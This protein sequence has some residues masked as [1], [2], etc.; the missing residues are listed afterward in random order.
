MANKINKVS[1]ETREKIRK[2]SVLNLPN[3][4]IGNPE[5]V[6]QAFTGLVIDS[7]NSALGEIDR[8]VEEI[9][10]KFDYLD[11]RVNTI[12]TTP[13][14]SVSAEE[15]IDA[16]QGEVTL[17]AN[18][19][20]VKSQ[21]ADKASLNE[22]SRKRDKSVPIGLNDV[23]PELL[24]AIEGGEGTSFELLS[25]PRDGSVTREKFDKMKP[26]KNVFDKSKTFFGYNISATNGKTSELSTRNLSDFTLIDPGA[27]YIIAQVET[28][29]FFDA[30]KNYISGQKLDAF[31]ANHLI[32]TPSNA[33]YIRF[34]WNAVSFD[35][36]RQMLTKGSEIPD[37]YIAYK[38]S[39][40]DLE[41][42]EDNLNRSLYQQLSELK[43]LFDERAY[44]GNLFNINAI[45]PFKYLN[46]NNGDLIDSA[47]R[48][49]SDFIPI[50]PLTLY[51]ISNLRSYVFYDENKNYIDGMQLSDAKTDYTIEAPRLARY[52]RFDY[53]QNTG[54]KQMVVEGTTVP[55]EFIPFGFK[56]PNLIIDYNNLDEALSLSLSKETEGKLSSDY[57]WQDFTF[58][59]E[60]I[61]AFRPSDVGSADGTREVYILDKDTLALNKTLRHNFGHA[62]TIDYCAETDSLIFGNG[63]G[64]YNTDGEI[65][66]V[67]GVKHLRNSAENTLIDING[68]TEGTLITKIEVFREFGDKVNVCWGEDNN[69]LHNICYVLSN[70]NVN[71]RKLLLG[72]GSNQFDNGQFISGRNENEFNGTYKI[73]SEYSLQRERI[74]VN[75]GT[76]Y[77]NG[78][79][80]CAMG[81][82]GLLMV[83]YK[84]NSDGTISYE[85]KHEKFYD[86]TGQ[87]IS[88]ASEGV[89]IKNGMIY[90]GIMGDIRAMYKYRVF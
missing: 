8:V 72:M 2:K 62:N 59:G 21:L 16:R 43:R 84:L 7:N 6:K 10:N 53:Y 42:E 49:T 58:V 9:N 79:L 50:K 88:C 57:T 90:H 47:S 19:T 73:L 22:V 51:T 24:A 1:N 87:E 82:D 44:T 41:I 67:Q 5:L 35:L 20:K 74:E 77:Y 71:V 61:W 65:Y 64:Q 13:V 83:R 68:T 17:G 36:N 48:N 60:E 40:P 11:S 39:L 54:E 86:A 80:Y 3:R 32:T 38:F 46:V 63:S 78:Y 29:V 89:A 70:D 85:T 23:S 28:Y 27:N 37:E 81:H 76:C 14:E 45:M 75:Q 26:S 31:T 66:I 33:K 69:G 25:V 15:I 55:E 30:D 56:E 4:I 34:T 12:L 18:I 52:L